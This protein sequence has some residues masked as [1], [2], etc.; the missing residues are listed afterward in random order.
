MKKFLVFGF[1]N[2]LLLNVFSQKD[3][4]AWK[5]EKNL[6]RQ[7]SVLKENSS[8]WNGYLMIKDPELNQFH[9]SIL[10]TVKGL[11]KTIGVLNSHLIKSKEEAKLLSEQLDETQK[12][13][14][15]SALRENELVTLGMSF[16]K[17][18]FPTILYSI[19]SFLVLVSAIAF[20]LFFRCKTVTEEMDTQNKVLS[21]ELQT[22]KNNNLIREAK[23]ARQLQTERNKNNSK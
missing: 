2:L 4:Q 20:L 1:L 8:K 23:L 22:Q 7:Y 5:V 11:E 14:E 19:I 21:E 6:E 17:N 13:L 18:I 15:A 16:N 10:D 9:N 3:S 12:E